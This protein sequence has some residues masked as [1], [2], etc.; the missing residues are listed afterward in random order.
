MSNW[1]RIQINVKRN[2]F[3][4]FLFD[5]RYLSHIHDFTNKKKKKKKKPWNLV[6]VRSGSYRAQIFYTCFLGLSCPLLA[7]VL[8]QDYKIRPVHLK[9][10]TKVILLLNMHSGVTVKEWY[11]YDVHESFKI[12]KDL[13]HPPVLFF[14]PL[15]RGRTISNELPHLLQ[16]MI[17]HVHVSKK[18]KAETKLSTPHSNWS[19]VLFDLGNNGFIKGWFHCLRVKKSFMSTIY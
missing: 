15:D 5:G 12:S 17:V 11:T 9:F 6:M 3:Q 4:R 8:L 10:V 7:Y 1:L 18:L 14:N 13:F 19:R 2:S 16:Q